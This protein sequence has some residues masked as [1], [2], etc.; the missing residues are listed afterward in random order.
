MTFDTLMQ[1]IGRDRKPTL[2]SGPTLR[3]AFRFPYGPFQFKTE[4]PEGT[5]YEIEG[6]TDLKNW[7]VIS[8]DVAGTGEIEFLD[9]SVSKSSHR[10]YR[11]TAGG[12]YSTN[13]IGFVAMNLPPG[14][15][16][17]AN[18]LVSSKRV[19]EMFKDWPNGTTLNRFDTRLFRM[20][21]NSVRSGVWTNPG[22][23]LL[24]GHGA[25]IFNP[26]NDYKLLTFVGEVMQGNL[27]IPIPSGFSV[28][29]AL[30]PQPGHLV[31]D[32]RFP[33]AE[34]DVIH[35]YDRDRQD[36]VLHPYE[37]GKWKNG[38]PIIGVGEAF[39]VAKTVAGNWHR[40]FSVND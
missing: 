17:I 26:A 22:E 29:S 9:S 23:Q 18:P 38:A 31:D 25:I 19:G 15:S 35:I 40:E 4:L 7:T 30:L 32:L 24:P 12:F 3:D 13:V 21:T 33:I 37:D 2:V 6:S 27:S 10:F 8:R 28:R 16:L 39:W 5:A 11:V 14:F 36:Y 1:K 20:C 34:G